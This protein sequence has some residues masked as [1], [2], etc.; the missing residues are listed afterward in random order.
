M[1]SGAAE[2]RKLQPTLKS[3]PKPQTSSHPRTRHYRSPNNEQGR[4]QREAEAVTYLRCSL[5][6]CELLLQ[7][8]IKLQD[9]GHV[10]ASA[11]HHKTR[12]RLQPAH[13]PLNR[14]RKRQAYGISP[15]NGRKEHSPTEKDCAT[16]SLPFTC[17]RAWGTWLALSQLATA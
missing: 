16:S 5:K 8:L 3:R 10:S 17:E 15:S 7:M 12:V 2:H 14:C 11:T 13:L 6:D 9:G 4:I 1:L